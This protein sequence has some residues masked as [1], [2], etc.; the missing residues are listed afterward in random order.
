MRL[1][2][3]AGIMVYKYVDGAP[4]FLFMKRHQFLDLPKGHIEKGE[5]AY[6]AAIRETKEE[7][8][9]NVRPA[10]F[11]RHQMNYYFK[12]G[13]TQIRKKVTMFLGEMPPGQKVTVSKE[14]VGYEWLNLEQARSKLKFRE[15]RMLLEKASEYVSRMERM[16][17]LNS[18]YSKLP[19]SSSNWTLSRKLV[20]GEGPLDAKIMFIG[21]APGDTEDRTGR[22]FVG[23]SGVLLD[24]LL[25]MA[26]LRREGVYITSTV[27][28]FPPLNRAPS[29][30]E[31][32]L[33]RPFISGQIQIIKPRLIVLVGLVAT[34]ALLGGDRLAEIHGKLAKRDGVDYFITLHP[35]AAVRI[36]SNMPLI[37]E[38]FRNLGKVAK[39]FSRG[40]GGYLPR[41]TTK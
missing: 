17:K 24:S 41:R 8:G 18:D 10:P 14:H 11:F 30:A 31:I 5:N 27:Q 39:A 4:S 37:E 38:D 16:E 2:F 33:C 21:Q 25:R 22:P 36:R 23:R 26:G 3:S 6:T 34:K 19:Q 15:H 12:D 29:D 1:E 32:N 28:F 9:I 7:A 40:T 35:A 20:K 13:K